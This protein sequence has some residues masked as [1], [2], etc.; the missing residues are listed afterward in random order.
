M[1]PLPYPAVTIVN[2]FP[3]NI[4][5]CKQIEISSNNSK[6]EHFFSYS[7]INRDE[8]NLDSRRYKGFIISRPIKVEDA[9]SLKSL[10]THRFLFDIESNDISV[11]VY[12]S[13]DLKAWS[14]FRSFSGRGFKYYKYHIIFNN[15]ISTDTFS[16]LIAEWKMKFQRKFR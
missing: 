4:I 7:L 16:G 1:K 15:L 10:A 6:T 13:D 8:I 2:D 5:V 3:D 14:R 12:G 11:R 9:T